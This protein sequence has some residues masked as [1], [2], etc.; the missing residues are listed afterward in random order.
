MTWF[1][2]NLNDFSVSFLSILFE[3]VPFMFIGT[4]LSGFIDAFVSPEALERRLP[5]NRYVAIGMSGILGAVLP[6]CECG[7]VPVIRRM[8]TKG[9]PVSAA[10]TYL[11]AAPIV[12]PIVAV[13]T[14]AAFRGQHPWEVMTLRLVLGFFVAVV[15]GWVVEHLPVHRILNSEMMGRLPTRTMNFVRVHK[16]A[17]MLVTAGGGGDPLFDAPAHGHAE[18]GHKHHNRGPLSKKILGAVRCAATDFLGVA[19]YLVIGAAITS[20][21]NTA[22]NRSAIA[23]LAGHAWAA[24]PSMMVLALLLS[25]CSTS[26]AFIAANFVAFPLASKLAFIVLGPMMDVKLLFMY[27]LMFRKRFTLSL[28]AGLFIFIGS[29]CLL[30]THFIRL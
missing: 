25:L 30:V 4:L 6:M 2:F 28:A 3:G 13:S 15:V 16:P 11:L 22:V 9:Y 19:F 18:H 24:T 23:P 5:K 27:G 17:P 21:F 20:L 29:L 1:E 26:D 12:N 14:F 10:L 8:V 7:I